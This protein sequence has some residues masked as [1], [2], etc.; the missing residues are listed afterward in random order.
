MYFDN[1]RVKNIINPIKKE[2]DLLNQQLQKLS[3]ENFECL[4][5][6]IYLEKLTVKTRTISNNE[7]SPTIP[8]IEEFKNLKRSARRGKTFCYSDSFL[9][10][11]SESS[12][13][14]KHSNT[15]H[16]GVLGTKSSGKKTF[17]R[18]LE[19]NEEL[20]SLDH[21]DNVK[22]HFSEKFG[23]ADI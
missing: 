16:V 18:C 20:K 6:S 5:E 2:W 22:K 14:N 13:T 8:E 12:V 19:S 4:D 23:E 7:L 17:L 9:V 10:S 11:N 21:I 1:S 15:I 3:E